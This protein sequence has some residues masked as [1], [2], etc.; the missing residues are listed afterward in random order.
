MTSHLLAIRFGTGLSPDHPVPDEPDALMDDLVG[1]DVAEAAFPVSDWAQ[2]VV[3]LRAFVDARRA[4]RRATEQEADAAKEAVRAQ[5]AVLVRNYG[6]DLAAALARASIAPT[7]FRE[8]LVWFWADHFAVSDG[9]SYLRRSVGAYHDA[10]IRPH[11]AGSF[12]TLLREA[13]THPAMLSY[14]DQ[15]RSVGPNSPRGREGAGLNENLARE[16]LELHTLGVDGPYTQTDVRE[17]AELLTGLSISRDGA[18]RFRRNFVE[19]GPETVLGKAYG[20]ARPNRHDI[21]ILL[22][23]LSVHPATARHVSQKLAVH[24][25]ADEPPEDL[26][27]VMVAAWRQSGGNL[28]EVYRV[29]VTHPTALSPELRKV[30]RPLDLVAAAARATGQGPALPTAGRR[31]LRRYVAQPLA[32]MGQEWLRPPG[33][34][35]WPEEAAAW[36]TPQGLAARLDWAQDV[37]QAVDTDPRDFLEVALGPLASARTRFAV[38]AAE[39][40]AAG[41]ALVLAAPE[42]QRR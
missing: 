4:Q 17:L 18:P 38:E 35:G 1:P 31:V 40:R 36:V 13:V 37:G 24:F 10:A 28:T 22:D 29:L 39:D 16:I 12:G 27:S 9:Q 14:L 19:P 7:G 33:P 41:I 23:D 6:G 26:V 30:R 32:A 2:R 34:H 5:Q 42:F 8:R 21:G 11:L 3:D 15:E 25:V 20:G